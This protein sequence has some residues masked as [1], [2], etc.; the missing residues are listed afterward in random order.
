MVS[1]SIR[2]PI[3]FRHLVSMSDEDCIYYP[4]SIWRR[5]QQFVRKYEV[6]HQISE[7]LCH[8]ILFWI[9]QNANGR[10]WREILYGLIS[11]HRLIRDLALKDHPPER[12]GTTVE[13]TP[14]PAS[15]L[16]PTQLGHF[17]MAIHNLMPVVL[18]ISPIE[19]RSQVRLWLE[20]CKFIPRLLTMGSY[21]Y[22]LYRHDCWNYCGLALSSGRLVSHAAKIKNQRSIHSNVTVEQEIS[23]RRREN[24]VGKRTGRRVVS[25]M[26][27]TKRTLYSPWPFL[28]GELW[29]LYRP[30]HWA[31]IEYQRFPNKID[32][33]TSFGLDIFSICL[34]EYFNNSDRN[35]E[36]LK[37]RK[38][39]L[40]LYLLRSPIYDGSTA[41]FVIYVSKLAGRIPMF[42]SLFESFILDWLSYWKHPFVSEVD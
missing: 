20:W 34:L 24:Y 23:L 42:G 33:F 6:Y 38:M 36:E 12:Y 1:Y 10:R 8:Q 9:P 21:W 5:Y 26:P 4:P 27:M 18:E 31:N 39:K 30:L 15:K 11:L 35:L 32:F 29:H 7:E 40:L 19:H 22:Q 28:L 41:P 17:V 37:R 13:I 3:W 16:S 25:S 14:P 2:S